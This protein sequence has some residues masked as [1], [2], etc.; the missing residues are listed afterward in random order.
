[1]EYSITLQNGSFSIAAA[2]ES[3]KISKCLNNTTS[4]GK[5][6][7]YFEFCLDFS[8]LFGDICFWINR[9]LRHW[10][11]DTE[12]IAIPT[13]RIKEILQAIQ[14]QHILIVGDVMLDQYL[15]G[16]V[17]RISPEAP[18]PVVEID[19]ESVRLGG[20]ANVAN[21]IHSLGAT[22]ILAGVIG[23]DDNGKRFMAE[24]DTQGISQEGLVLDE[25][26]PTTIKTR[27]IAHHQH[28]LRTDRELKTPVGRKIEKQILDVINDRLG[29]V[30]A[31]L[32]QDYN[33][34][35]VTQNLIKEITTIT[36]NRN[37]IL[38]VDPKQKHFF[39]YTGATVFKPNERE[40][41]GALRISIN[42]DE[43]LEKAG[44]QILKR[45]KCSNLLI[46]RGDRGMVLFEQNG[47]IIY[48]PTRA[49][50]VFDVSGAGDTTIGTLTSA[51][52]AGASITEA[53]TMAN[54]AA[55]I[56]CGE[57]GIV[58]ITR[59]KLLETMKTAVS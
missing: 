38:T 51:L 24:L 17:H 45:L 39:D 46:T 10:L 52:A 6:K 37:T 53:A 28:V 25:T 40:V 43:S 26:R 56:V 8:C 48:V 19:S 55:G 16:S 4:S 11:G 1:M 27:V 35:L 36:N 34:G 31:I 58:P 44:T 59:D 57:V 42:G 5:V 47:N 32:I 18:V 13:K 14:E 22:P 21:N 33:K 49:K 12:L 50:E 2:C 54:Y 7:R 30:D 20:A 23:A 9:F 29:T 41:E 3:R 15:W